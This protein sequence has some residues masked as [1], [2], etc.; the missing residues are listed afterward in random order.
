MRWELRVLVLMVGV[1]VC[2]CAGYSV[3]ENGQ[4]VGYD[5]YRPEPYLQGEG[6]TNP[7]GV[8][9]GYKFTLVWLPNY[10]KRY[11][12]HS[13][14]GFGKADFTFKFDDGWRLTQIDDRAS[15]EEVLKSL[16]DLAKHILP[17]N[18]FNLTAK[19]PPTKGFAAEN[20][21]PLLYKIDIDDCTGDVCLREVKRGEPT[22]VRAR[23]AD[24]VGGP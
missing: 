2:G 9:T 3:Q 1:T 22:C 17:E 13:W 10:S 6:V 14:A 7:A 5:V 21:V 20:P 18:P 4:G 11:R 16:T 12:V 19:A 24:G 23:G 8:V 15:N